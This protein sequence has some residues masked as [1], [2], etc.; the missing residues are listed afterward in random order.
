MRPDP[1][2]YYGHIGGMPEENYQALTLEDFGEIPEV[3][4]T[5]EQI[6]GAVEL[7]Q[8]P[9]EQ[10]IGRS[11]AELK[12]LERDIPLPLATC[13]QRIGCWQ[14]IVQ[15]ACRYVLTRA[16]QIALDN[17]EQKQ[18]FAATVERKIMG[19]HLAYDEIEPNCIRHGNKCDPRKQTTVQAMM[20]GDIMEIVLTDQ[21]A[22]FPP[23][24]NAIITTTGFEIPEPDMLLTEESSG[25]GVDLAR[26]FVDSLTFEMNGR[27]CRIRKSCADLPERVATA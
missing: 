22:G 3:W 5:P 16:P 14:G 25:R 6:R 19:I 7:L 23:P 4:K 21:G 13:L 20:D 18:A 8:L 27:R 9:L 11:P 10:A 24:P 26:G 17:E 12:Q 2:R 15:L 1:L